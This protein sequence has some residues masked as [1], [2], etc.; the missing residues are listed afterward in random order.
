MASLLVIFWCKRIRRYFRSATKS[1]PESR[2]RQHN[3]RLF[4]FCQSPKGWCWT[5][6]STASLNFYQ[7]G[8][9]Y[10]QTYLYLRSSNAHAFHRYEVISRF[11]CSKYGANSTKLNRPKLGWISS[12]T[13]RNHATSFCASTD[14][15]Q[16]GVEAPMWPI[17]WSGKR[18][19][20]I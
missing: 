17:W 11:F 16:A 5:E 6:R 10:R 3:A 7:R 1:A 15:P 19:A 14:W 2:N 8:A 20:F 9:I 18:T 4:E 12:K 13:A